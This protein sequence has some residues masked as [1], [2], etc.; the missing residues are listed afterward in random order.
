MEG[1]VEGGVCCFDGGD[2]VDAIDAS[3]DEGKDGIGEGISD[4][5]E[6]E[7]DV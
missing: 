5:D 1:T 7:R 3:R 6:E 4:E 2:G